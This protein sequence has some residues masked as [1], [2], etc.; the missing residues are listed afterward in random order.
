MTVLV[1]LLFPSTKGYST[2]LQRPSAESRLSAQR[3]YRYIPAGISL[4]V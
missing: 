1:A 3:V 4:Q 2:D